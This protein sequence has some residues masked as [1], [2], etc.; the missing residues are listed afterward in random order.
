MLVA[1]G[2]VAIVVG[3]RGGHDDE[4]LAARVTSWRGLVVLAAGLSIDNLAVGFS[5]GLGD[6]SPVVVATAIM[7]FSVTFTWIGIGVGAAGRRHWERYAEFGA[8]GLLVALGI[9]AGAGFV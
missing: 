4:R 6:A 7:L 2:L 3:T 9:A 1:L 8:G 5:L